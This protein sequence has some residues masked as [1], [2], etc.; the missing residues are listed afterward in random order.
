[1]WLLTL[2]IIGTLIS[3]H[4]VLFSSCFLLLF[5]DA[6]SLFPMYS[7]LYTCCTA[8]PSL[9]LCMSLADGWASP[10]PVVLV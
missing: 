2:I 5:N 10:P 7:A 4:C 3:D 8:L 9:D 1:M 6:L